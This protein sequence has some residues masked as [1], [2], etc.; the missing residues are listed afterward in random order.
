MKFWT[1]IFG[2]V[3][4]ITTLF[5]A[6]EIAFKQR[7]APSY[8]GY[9]NLC[10]ANAV[11]NEITK[12]S[13]RVYENLDKTVFIDL[14]ILE[15]GDPE[16]CPEWKE[17]EPLISI[18]GELTSNTLSLN[19]TRL[20]IEG[21][22]TTEYAPQII[23]SLDIT[24]LQSAPLVTVGEGKSDFSG[25]N[26]VGLFSVKGNLAAGLHSITLTPASANDVNTSKHSCNKALSH[27]LGYFE[28]GYRYI[29]EC[30]F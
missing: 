17:D 22:P 18:P 3:T 8:A 20:E 19:A 7:Y 28:W 26:V 16:K 15:A 10:E 29:I 4:V 12:L 27:D 13:T 1:K 23:V 2:G 11:L 24:T 25:F 5:G 30:V 14:D 6:Y 9:M 21:N